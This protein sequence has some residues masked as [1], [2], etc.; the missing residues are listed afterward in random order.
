[1]VL[2]SIPS[3]E[4]MSSRYN[5]QR[6]T[7]GA[8]TKKLIILA[9]F[10]F[11]HDTWVDSCTVFF[12]LKHLTNQLIDFYFSCVLRSCVELYFKLSKKALMAHQKV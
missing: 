11:A 9:D 10:Y 5:G 7:G 12:N 8:I 1:M 4:Q 2:G 6:R 3:D